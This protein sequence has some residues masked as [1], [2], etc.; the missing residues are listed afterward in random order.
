MVN[1]THELLYGYVSRNSGKILG[2]HGWLLSL[3]W[4]EIGSLQEP[5]DAEANQR[6]DAVE[7]R[8]GLGK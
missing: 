2:G 4:F 6:Q 3:V 8:G 1:E 5:L 7:I